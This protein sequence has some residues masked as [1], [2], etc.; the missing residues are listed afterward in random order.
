MHLHKHNV[1][2]YCGNCK[3]FIDLRKDVPRKM[4]SPLPSLTEIHQCW[5]NFDAAVFEEIQ[6][7]GVCVVVWDEHRLFIGALS[8]LEDM[9]TDAEKTEVMAVMRAP[10]EISFSH[11]S[12]TGCLSD[13]TN[14]EHEW[15][16]G[17]GLAVDLWSKNHHGGNSKLIPNAIVSLK[18]TLVI[19]DFPIGGVP[20]HK[21]VQDCPCSKY[22]DKLLCTILGNTTGNALGEAEVDQ[23]FYNHWFLLLSRIQIPDN[24]STFH[25]KNHANVQRIVPN[26]LHIRIDAAHSP[27]M[28]DVQE[29]DLYLADKIFL[30]LVFSCQLSTFP[31]NGNSSQCSRIACIQKIGI[32]YHRKAILYLHFN[33]EKS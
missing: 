12:R 6:K 1:S 2:P 4:N 9:I 10:E 33:W 11:V 15:F 16:S 14:A 25:I 27:S 5:V 30:K 29:S 22:P 23:C 7:I 8:S 32:S 24:S 26:R 28:T 17:R 3:V 21:M 31:A 19:I 20:Q 18:F 13:L